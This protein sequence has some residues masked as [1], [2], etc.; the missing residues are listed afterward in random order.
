[1]C[2]FFEAIKIKDGIIIRLKYHQQRVNKA[3]E[4]YYPSEQTIS[5]L[6]ELNQSVIPQEGTYKCRI[7][8]SDTVHSVEITPY[9]MREIKSLKLVETDLESF[10]YKLDD[11]SA[12]KAAFEQR[13]GCDDVL[14][15]KN[16]LLTD[17]SYSNIALFDGENWYTPQFPLLYGTNRAELIENGK[18]VEKDIRVSDLKKYKRIALF[19]AMIEFGE[20]ILD[21]DKIL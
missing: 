6:D 18:I 5:L 13:E 8:Y 12:Y 7:V 20:L 4:I 11:R 21:T 15:Y 14:L 19:N 17:T 3:F 2:Q 9:Q 10:T 16:D 1:M